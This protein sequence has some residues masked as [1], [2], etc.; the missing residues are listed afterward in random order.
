MKAVKLLEGAL[1]AT[2]AADAGVIYGVVAAAPVGGLRSGSGQL[3][4]M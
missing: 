2:A 3:L 1:A 4:L